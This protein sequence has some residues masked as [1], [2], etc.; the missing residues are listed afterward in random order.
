M[1]SF[2]GFGL[3]G[4]TP[5]F[6]TTF[7]GR[8]I[9]RLD[10]VTTDHRFGHVPPHHGMPSGHLAVR[11]YLGMPVMGRDGTVLGGLVF[12]HAQPGVFTAAAELA[13]RA[14]ATHAAVAVENARFYEREH[15]VAVTLQRS[16]LPEHL[17]ELPTVALAARY[18]PAAAQAEVG[19]DW[20]DALVLPD[21]RLGLSV[22]DV[23]GHD[24]GAAATMGQLRSALR[25]YM[26][27]C[28]DAAEVV[29]RL[30]QFM[31][32]TSLKKFTT[33]TY[34]V[35]DPR[36]RSLQVVRAAH[37]PPLL[38][39]AD[40]DTRYLPGGATPPLGISLIGPEALATAAIT[41]TLQPGTTA[42]FFTDGLIE[43][44]G[45][46]LD[47]GMAALLAAATAAPSGDAE[48]LC[49]AVLATLHGHGGDDTVLL[50]MTVR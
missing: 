31:T 12:G 19:G 5:L 42:L 48:S 46:T 30:D 38:V 16:L 27:E 3:P 15:T 23:V 2:E 44:R 47:E 20:Y 41:V 14:I 35:F 22:G 33:L 6:A 43:R 26:L 34:A 32:A 28:S 18:L 45:R 39:S 17:P 24:I 4:N 21:G 11:S 9:V 13:V 49:D 10:D 29:R 1:D 8:G 40:G 25:A 50:A 37:P 36:D 7:T